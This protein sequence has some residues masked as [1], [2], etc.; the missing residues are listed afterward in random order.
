MSTKENQDLTGQVFGW[1][2]VL[3]RYEDMYD[4]NGKAIKQW[5]CQ[6]KCGNECIKREKI[7]AI[8]RGVYGDD[9]IKL[10]KLL[11]ENFQKQ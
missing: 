10:A 4:K 7:I 8:M 5:K 6:C 3:E 2:V 9:C 1:L 11:I